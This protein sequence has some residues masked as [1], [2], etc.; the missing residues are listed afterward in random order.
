MFTFPVL[1]L[2][3]SFEY[4]VL[5]KPCTL[6][7]YYSIILT[8][9]E[10]IKL[11]M[12]LSTTSWKCM[13]A[14]QLCTFWNFKPDRLQVLAARPLWEKPWVSLTWIWWWKRNV[15][16]PAKDWTLVIQS[17]AIIIIH[18]PSFLSIQS[19]TVIWN[20][21]L[22]SLRSFCFCKINEVK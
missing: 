11:S 2:D 1:I 5:F 20:C 6:I 14:L 10:N 3:Y 7:K 22:T 21:V 4:R 15:F 17:R 16:A 19:N 9:K 12:C 8:I 18:C 13:R